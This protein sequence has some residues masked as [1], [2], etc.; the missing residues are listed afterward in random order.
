ML[1]SR[2][3]RVL[4]S[5]LFCVVFMPSVNAQIFDVAWTFGNVGS[6]SYRL[7]QYSPSD[8]SFGEVGASDP[9]L[10]LQLGYRYQVTVQNYQ[11]HPFEVLGKAVSPGDDI[12]LLSMGN[13]QGSF[14]SDPGVNWNDDGRGTVEFTLTQALHEGMAQGGR[15]PGYRCRPHLFS[16]RGD[17]KID[18]LPI[19]PRIKPGN[20]SIDLHLIAS[21]L[22]AP[23]DLQPLPGTDELY[24]ADQAGTIYRIDQGA[25]VPFLDVQDRLVQL[26]ILGSFDEDDYDERGLLGFAFHPGYGDNQSPGYHRLYTHTSEPV[27]GPADFQVDT[28]PEPLNHQSVILEWRA[29]RD[30]RSVSS[31][32]HREIMRVDQPQFNHNGGSLAFDQ[33]GYLYVGLGDGGAANDQGEGHG[34][35]GNGQNLETVL[36]S[37]LRIDPVN[38]DSTSLSRDAVSVNGAYR[39]PWDNPFVGI[40]GVDEIYAYGFR[41]PYRFSFDRLSDMLVVADVGQDN[42]E[43]INIVRKGGNYGWSIKEGTFL[44]DPEGLDLGVPWPDSS[45]TDP[46]VQYDHDDGLSAIGGFMYYGR[47]VP[48]LRAQYVFGDF[49]TGFFS[50]GGRLFYSDLLSGEISELRLGDEKEPLNL[51]LK[52]FGQD[53]RGEVYVLASSSLGPFGTQGVVLKLVGTGE[54]GGP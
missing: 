27:S 35:E 5:F 47:S 1:Y 40:D 28:S 45:L 23:V 50:P 43:E 19:V 49:S 33:D 38:P 14:E 18:G 54:V 48:E 2:F 12:V 34:S 24:V 8:V 51:F 13:A 15:I 6:S 32:A 16:M 44:F 53:S 41:N 11:M 30:G 46:V 7:D 26:G 21:G 20:P 22:A 37:I 9:T 4:T 52:G 29:S 3:Q 10:P 39:V 31:G 42:V 17:F 25:L 36:G